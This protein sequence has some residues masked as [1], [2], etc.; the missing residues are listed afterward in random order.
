MT[1][2][3]INIS[4]LLISTNKP[5]FTSANFS[6]LPSSCVATWWCLVG[7]EVMM[8]MNEGWFQ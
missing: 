6:N 2:T 1:D 8:M 4:F 3:N 5:T 7:M